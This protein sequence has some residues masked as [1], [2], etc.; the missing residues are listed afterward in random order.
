M[1]IETNDLIDEASGIELPRVARMTLSF[2]APT[3]EL[4]WETTHAL[5]DLLIDSARARQRAALLRE[6]AGAESAVE[7]AE[8]SSELAVWQRPLSAA[9]RRRKPAAAPWDCARPR[10]ADAA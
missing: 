8:L 2:I 10:A 3:P 7:R 4:A 6:Q 1:D 9:S 5:A